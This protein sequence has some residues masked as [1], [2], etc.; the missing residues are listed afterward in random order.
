MF[1]YKLTSPSGKVYIG[2]AGNPARRW[3]EHARNARSGKASYLYEAI[4]KYG[5]EAF[6]KEIIDS[7]QSLEELNQKEVYWIAYYR[8]YTDATKGYNSTPGGDGGD[9]WSTLS[10]EQKLTAIAKR[11]AVSEE[12][13]KKMSESRK[14]LLEGSDVWNK[15]TT[16]HK[17]TVKE[18]WNKGKKGEYHRRSPVTEETKRKLREARSH[19]AITEETK[20]KIRETLSG[21]KLSEETRQKMR[22]A[23]RRRH[24]KPKN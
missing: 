2:K 6:T 17:R 9:T 22:D 13:R 21:R 10:E 1:I 11:P 8:S 23:Q 18:P 15:G 14:H 3:Q 24:A 19:Q 16:W 4:R 7:A 12:T 5:W 20:Q